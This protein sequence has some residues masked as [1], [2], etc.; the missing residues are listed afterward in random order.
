MLDY[1]LNEEAIRSVKEIDDKLHEGNLD[2]KTRT[3][4]M[5]EQMLRG[6]SLGQYR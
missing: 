5:F 2:G 1:E 4:L 6:L 3:R